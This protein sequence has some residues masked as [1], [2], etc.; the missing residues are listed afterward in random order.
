M[1]LL[2]PSVREEMHLLENTVLTVHVDIGVKVTR[3]VAQYSLHHVTH[4]PAKFKVA[5]P[6]GLGNAFTRNAVLT[7]DHDLEIKVTEDVAQY[8]MH[9]QSV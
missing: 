2:R 7:F 3:N 6:N 1:K 4:A 8:S 9:M 5:S